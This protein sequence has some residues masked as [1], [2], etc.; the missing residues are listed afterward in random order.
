MDSELKALEGRI[1][2][3]VEMCQRLRAENLQLRQQLAAAKGEN[4]QLAEKIGGARDRL[5]SLLQKIPEG[6]EQ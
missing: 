3:F 5:E 1:A 4:K 6:E 2:Q